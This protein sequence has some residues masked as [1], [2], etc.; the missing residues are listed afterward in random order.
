MYLFL[1]SEQI[2]IFS[3]FLQGILDVLELWYKTQQ[4][5][6]IDS[7]SMNTF[8]WYEKTKNKYI[9]ELTLLAKKQ[10]HSLYPY[11]EELSEKLIASIKTK[12]A[13]HRKYKVIK[14]NDKEIIVLKKVAHDDPLVEVIPA[15]KCFDVMAE[16]H[17][18]HN[19]A[20]ATEMAAILKG[21]YYVFHHVIKIFIKA[22]ATC[23]PPEIEKQK[24]EKSL[25]KY[26]AE[27]TVDCNITP[28][29]SN[30]N[31]GFT[32][33]IVY[34]DNYTNYTLVRPTYS[35]GYVEFAYEILK[36]FLDFGLPENLI[37]RW[38]DEYTT[39]LKR[40]LESTDIFA[41]LPSLCSKTHAGRI[42]W[43]ARNS[44][45]PVQSWTSNSSNWAITISELQWQLN[46][47][48]DISKLKSRKLPKSQIKSPYHAHF[49]V[50]P[51]ENVIQI[52]ET[53]EDT[54]QEILMESTSNKT[55]NFNGYCNNCGKDINETYR[56][57]VLCKKKCHFN[58]CIFYLHLLAFDDRRLE[59]TCT[60]CVTEHRSEGNQVS[61]RSQTQVSQEYLSSSLK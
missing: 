56:V 4:Y 36:I 54:V 17:L 61:V 5:K 30:Q 47:S 10:Q 45:G 49:G 53:S 19:H 16:I 23:N 6:M 20:K 43:I 59:A 57:C 50:L 14:N 31:N 48:G 8:V 35:A 55:T 52:T 41:H 33:V 25:P 34:R 26:I 1:K 44:S 58:C 28:V 39:V 7:D 60:P 9:R 37:F 51:Y 12:G 32:H 18:Q 24:V 38:G 42:G 13:N 40:I 27:F 11:T 2:N 29:N 46:N 3:L 15:T 22:C 21:V